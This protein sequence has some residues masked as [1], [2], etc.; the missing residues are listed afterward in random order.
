MASQIGLF[1][2]AEGDT[3]PDARRIAEILRQHL[4]PKFEIT[5]GVSGAK[6]FLTGYTGY[7]SDDI[8]TIKK[9]AYHGAVVAIMP[10]R[11]DVSWRAIDV[12]ETTPNP[13]LEQLGKSFGYLGGL[14]FG[15][16]FSAIFGNGD[17][18]YGKLNDIMRNELKGEEVDAS[19][20]NNV[21]AMFQG[22]SVLDE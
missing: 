18:L 2:I 14:L 1:K 13:L 11:E 20:L 12:H 16:L 5:V 22:K 10:K 17:D 9:N 19:V 4:D 21:K 8:I 7:N 15:H 3:M 6:K